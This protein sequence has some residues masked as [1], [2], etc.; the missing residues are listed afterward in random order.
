MKMILIAERDDIPQQGIDRGQSVAPHIKVEIAPVGLGRYL[1]TTAQQIGHTRQHAA[2]DT[3]VVQ[4]IDIFFIRRK[5]GGREF[6]DTPIL[7]FYRRFTRTARRC[8]RMPPGFARCL[9]NYFDPGS[10][11]AER[12]C[13][14]VDDK[15]PAT[16]AVVAPQ[17]DILNAFK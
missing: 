10:S 14:T 2:T 17:R 11:K 9:H 4:Q 8:Y 12:S 16:S 15:K 1:A 7:P 13:A 3:V 5:R 6:T